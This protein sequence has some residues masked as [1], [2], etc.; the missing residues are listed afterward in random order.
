ML[1][2]AGHTFDMNVVGQPR[3]IYCQK[4]YILLLQCTRED[5]GKPYIAHSGD[6][7][8]AEWDTIAAEQN[9]LMDACRS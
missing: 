3:C 5:I 9:R 7:T 8:E 6:L 4:P 1:Q 2:M